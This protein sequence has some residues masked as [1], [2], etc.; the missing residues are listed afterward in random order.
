MNHLDT[1]V[2]EGDKVFPELARSTKNSRDIGYEVRLFRYPHLSY[3]KVNVLTLEIKE[4]DTTL[5]SV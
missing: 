5:T 3:E 2:I 4:W 1:L